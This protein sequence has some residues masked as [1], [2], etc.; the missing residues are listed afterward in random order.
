MEIAFT[1]NRPVDTVRTLPVLFWFK[2][3]AATVEFVVCKT[4]AAQLVL[5]CDFCDRVFDAN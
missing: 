3:T 2:K 1:N 5:V 4:H